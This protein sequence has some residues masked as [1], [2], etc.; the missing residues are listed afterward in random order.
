MSTSF[1]I[2]HHWAFSWY[3]QT[4]DNWILLLTVLERVRGSATGHKMSFVAM[5]ESMRIIHPGLVHG[6]GVSVFHIVES[7]VFSAHIMK[8]DCHSAMRP[9]RCWWRTS[10]T[11]CWNADKRKIDWESE[12]NDFM[13]Q[14]RKV[15][16]TSWV[17]ECPNTKLIPW[18]FLSTT[19]PIT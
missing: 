15:R 5:S 10:R 6:W 17:Q 1:S 2:I 14:G 13:N 3:G 8:W 7:L 11:C 12:A 16:R 19:V 4:M 9:V 18:V